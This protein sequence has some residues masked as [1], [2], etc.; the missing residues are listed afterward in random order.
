[1]YA[2]KSG[3]VVVRKPVVLSVSFR[4]PAP[5]ETWFMHS[6]FFLAAYPKALCNIFQG[7]RMGRTAG[8]GYEEA[9]SS[10]DKRERT[11]M[12]MCVGHTIH[13]PTHILENCTIAYKIMCI[14]SCR[15]SQGFFKCC[16]FCCCC[17]SIVVDGEYLL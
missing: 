6:S 12:Q 17:F 16:F 8:R 14:K 13:I 1:M 2:T 5:V 9:T 15:P 4:Y 11:Q 10:L 7:T 3:S